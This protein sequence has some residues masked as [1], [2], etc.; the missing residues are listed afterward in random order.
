MNTLGVRPEVGTEDS[1]GFRAAYV[2][3]R[4]RRIIAGFRHV[5]LG[6]DDVVVDLGCGLGRPVYAAAWLGARR[7]IGV[8]MDGP[9]VEKAR[10]SH[11]GSR[12]RDRDI[13]FVCAPAETYPLDDATII[14]MFNPFGRGIMQGVRQQL[15]AALARR[16]RRLRI[17]YENPLQSAVLDESGHLRRTGEWPPG[18]DGSPYP[19][20]FWES[21]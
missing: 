16:P 10:H 6:P 7:S 19:M 11:R 17:A 1:P 9:L 18:K 8:E 5:G 21:T 14:F 15:D 12:L 13:E 20:A 3:T 2:P 4:Y